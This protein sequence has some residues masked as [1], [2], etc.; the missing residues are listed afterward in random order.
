MVEPFNSNPAISLEKLTKVYG[1]LGHLPVRKVTALSEVSLNVEKGSSV[2]LVGPNGAG[3]TTLIKI[4]LGL[5]RPT[6]GSARV[7][8]L[9]P[10]LPESRRHIGYVP[11]TVKFPGFYKA[12]DVLQT[13]GELFSLPR[14]ELGLRSK[15][16]LSFCGLEGWEHLEIRRCSKGMLQ[17]LAFAQ[18]LINDPDILLLD[19]PFTGMDV[20]ARKK[21]AEI[22]SGAKSKRGR[23]IILST[24]ILSDVV[25]LCDEVVILVAG[26]VHK[27]LPV[28]ELTRSMAYVVTISGD[29]NVSNEDEVEI[30]G[31]LFYREGS[32]L[33]AQVSGASSLSSFMNCLGKLNISI[34]SIEPRS[35]NFALL[36]QHGEEGQ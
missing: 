31:R 33:K 14:E 25:D 8:G 11:E 21:F 34:Q 19:E 35:F 30:C 17:K 16:L 15:Q 5:V 32:V 9:S 4:L 13:A 2:V 22:V 27:V 1:Q 28:V 24:H 7:C 29:A 18:A 6:S 20:V 12:I 10:H 3:K 26:K 23:T 36:F